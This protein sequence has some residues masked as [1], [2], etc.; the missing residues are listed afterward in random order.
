MSV[1]ISHQ[2]LH[3]VN[4]RIDFE[5]LLFT[6][7][8]MYFVSQISGYL[9]TLQI[10]VI[11]VLHPSRV[12][13]LTFSK[14]VQTFK[15]PIVVWTCSAALSMF[16]PPG[17]DTKVSFGPLC[18]EQLI[19]LYWVFTPSVQSAVPRHTHWRS[20]GFISASLKLHIL[21]RDKTLKT[22]LRTNWNRE[23][24]EAPGGRIQEDLLDNYSK[25]ITCFVFP[26]FCSVLKWTFANR[27]LQV[28]Y[29]YIKGLNHY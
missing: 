3:P 19:E 20:F 1:I 6:V 16:S 23:T 14:A 28:E 5:I 27:K 12:Q 2:F 21:Q 25:G 26:S 11:F 29:F 10:A 24:E 9:W 17:L 8:Y 18:S 4:F 22:G 15:F 13:R 7:S